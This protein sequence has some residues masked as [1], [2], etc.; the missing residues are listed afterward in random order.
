MKDFLKVIFTMIIGLTI[1]IVIY[2]L[3]HELGH[4][5]ACKIVGAEVSKFNLFPAYVN[6]NI[7]NISKQGVII[8]GICGNLIPTIVCMLITVLVKPNNIYTWYAKTH[9]AFTCCLSW[10][11]SL[12][13]IIAIIQGYGDLDIVKTEDIAQIVIK[14]PDIKNICIVLC[15]VLIVIS[16]TCMINKKSVKQLKDYLSEYLVIDN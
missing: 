9:L 1:A 12:V 15:V 16:A 13:N 8:I 5:T 11:L 14:Y 6:C 2:P 7:S 3:I 10:V 4:F